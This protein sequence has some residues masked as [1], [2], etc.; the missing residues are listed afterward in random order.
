V[1][2]PSGTPAL[3]LALSERVW[4]MDVKYPWVVAATADRKIHMY[5]LTAPHAAYRVRGGG[6][7]RLTAL[8]APVVACRTQR[9]APRRR[10]FS[11]FS[12]LQ[13]IES[14]L[15]H[16]TRVVRMF[17]EQQCYCIGTIEGRVA[18]RYIEER[19][20]TESKPG[21]ADKLKNSFSFRCH[22]QGAYIY[23]VN[24][25]DTH[26]H[27][28]YRDVFATAGSDGVLVFWN[29]A[30]K[31]KLK[32]YATFSNRNSIAA[33]AWNAAGTQCA[34]AASYDYHRGVEGTQPAQPPTQ[35]LVHNMQSEDM[36][37][38]A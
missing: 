8:H 23:P 22:R 35:L 27:A 34:Y 13:V 3:K 31:L 19:V 10:P 33:L 21:E 17:H 5:N 14:P 28:A 4:A 25:I 16:Q 26:P 32:E 36:Q 18:V 29:K 1:R 12:P 11:S 38:K 37:P 24:A 2:A 9:R 7:A 15:T 30:K 6:G 20:D